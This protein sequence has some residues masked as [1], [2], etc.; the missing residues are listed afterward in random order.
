MNRREEFEQLRY[1]HFPKQL[2]NIVDHQVKHY[3]RYQKTKTLIYKPLF[4]ICLIVL[5]S[6]FIFNA[7]PQTAYACKGIPLLEDFAKTFCFDPTIKD[8]IDNDYAI[9]LH[10]TRGNSEKLILEYMIVDETQ[11]TFYIKN[12]NIDQIEDVCFIK[13]K[14]YSSSV[15]FD[16]EW[17]KIQFIYNDITEIQFSDQLIFKSKEEYCFDIPLDKIKINSSK[18]IKL[19]QEINVDG[20]KLIIQKIM[21]YPSITKIYIKENQNN[22]KE[23]ANIYVSIEA[24]GQIYDNQ[25][26]GISA[27]MNDGYKVYMCKSP[28]FQSGDFKVN[29]EGVTLTSSIYDH[30]QIDV[31]QKKITPLPK[32]VK[33]REFK[34]KDKKLLLELQAPLYK[35]AYPLI[36]R[37][38]ENGKIMEIDNIQFSSLDDEMIIQM[39][40]IPYSKKKRYALD[41]DYQQYYSIDQSIKIH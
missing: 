20:Q 1:N 17:I 38:E 29:I 13:G 8:C 19:N 26:N 34:V 36:T 18:E 6:L 21:I 11:T 3:Y 14:G 25:I 4:S 35:T 5:T 28:Y 9:Y 24:N 23:L 31:S 15:V 37:Y 7:F 40:E 12:N 33:I 10:Q 16:N 30:C 27:Q 2:D 32:D 41:I 39:I 22:T